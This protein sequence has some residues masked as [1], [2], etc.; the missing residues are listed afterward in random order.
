MKGLTS[1]GVR[2]LNWLRPKIQPSTFSGDKLLLLA[3][4]SEIAFDELTQAGFGEY[5]DAHSLEWPGQQPDPATIRQ[6][7]ESAGVTGWTEPRWMGLGRYLRNSHPLERVQSF[8]STAAS[9][10]SAWPRFYTAYNRIGSRSRPAMNRA[11]YRP[12]VLPVGMSAEDSSN[13]SGLGGAIASAGGIVTGVGYLGSADIAAGAA[14]GTGLGVLGATL[15]LIA[16][17]I[18]QSTP[19][20][21][22][23]STPNGPCAD[24]ADPSACN[25]CADIS[26]IPE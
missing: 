20:Q 26:C 2:V 25:E 17:G 23:T 4:A 15:V 24:L 18:S 8:A 22:L 19:A 9:V 13:I 6:M 5:W 14:I 3:E 1:S 12:F 7:L 16:Y 11:A 21:P 10:Q